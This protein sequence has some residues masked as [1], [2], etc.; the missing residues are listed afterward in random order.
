VKLV[1]CLHGGAVARAASPLHPGDRALVHLARRL[2]LEPIAVELLAAGGVAPRAVNEAAA[3][4]LQRA[5][6]IVDDALGTAD[7][8]ATGLVVERVLRELK[9][10]LI[11]FVAAADPEGAAD[12]PAVVAF[13]M[14]AAYVPG[15]FEV[16]AVAPT[17][18]EAPPAFTARAWRGSSQ[19]TLA[20]PRGAV[21]EVDLSG[22]PAPTT[23]D[24]EKID[25]A[26]LTAPIRVVTLAD[27]ALDASLVRRR[28]DLRGV[29]EPTARPLVTTKSSTS[30]VALLR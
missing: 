2:G 24:A 12:V 5:V 22:A 15:A 13:R 29:I 8:P 30:L 14:G 6:R 26:G 7:A 16:A 1:I 17:A 4:G 28:D 20:L 11:T 9:A 18:A 10:D 27:L 3:A 19:V 21:V 23:N 25:K